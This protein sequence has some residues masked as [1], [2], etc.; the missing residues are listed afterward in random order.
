MRH[1]FVEL[2]SNCSCLS[3]KILGARKNP[4]FVPIID[5]A[6]LSTYVQHLIHLYVCNLEVVQSQ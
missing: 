3:F 2:L 1:V 4:S 6:I 5:R